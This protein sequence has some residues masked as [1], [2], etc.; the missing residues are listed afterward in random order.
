MRTFHNSILIPALAAGCMTSV[1]LADTRQAQTQIRA[2]YA[3]LARSF[4]ARSVSGVMA[5]VAPN[6]S[7]KDPD[8]KTVTRQQLAKR[9]QELMSRAKAINEAS[10]NV[11]SISVTR[12]RA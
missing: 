12:D 3:S 10:Y 2:N 6:W 11:K 9:F 7:M 5:H 1:V 8:G 4:K